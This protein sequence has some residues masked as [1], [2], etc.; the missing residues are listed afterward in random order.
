MSMAQPE[1]VS[2]WVT[3]IYRRMLTC[4]DCR[5]TDAK[6]NDCYP[7]QKGDAIACHLS[8]GPVSSFCR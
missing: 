3:A 1:S 5:I 2:R 8:I 6:S 7:R 4:Q